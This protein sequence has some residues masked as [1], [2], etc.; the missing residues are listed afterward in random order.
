[1]VSL[2]RRCAYKGWEDGTWILTAGATP[3]EPHFAVARRQYRLTRQFGR[4][5]PIRTEIPAIPVAYILR[6]E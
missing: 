6:R 5:A 3:A 1:M 4:E 2:G